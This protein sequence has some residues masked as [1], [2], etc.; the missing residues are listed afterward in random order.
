MVPLNIINSSKYYNL[1]YHNHT[2]AGDSFPTTTPNIVEKKFGVPIPVIMG[3]QCY[4]VTSSR[5]KNTA[6]LTSNSSQNV[7]TKTPKQLTSDSP[8][9]VETKKTK[10][11]TSK[12]PHNVETKKRK[13]V[14]SKSPQSVETKTPK[15]LTSKSQNV[16]E[17]EEPQSGVPSA[18][19]NQVRKKMIWVD[20]QAH[21]TILKF[22]LYTVIALIM[23]TKYQVGLGLGQLV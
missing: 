22:C 5:S 2:D 6:Q 3:L 12:S 23:V 15:K 11:L 17:P 13:Q 18:P 9:N 20:L 21:L 1:F 19:T 14:T 16:V 8:Q 10:Q 7:E 4:A